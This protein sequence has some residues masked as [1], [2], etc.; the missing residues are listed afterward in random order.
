MSRLWH[1]FVVNDSQKNL[2][3]ALHLAAEALD[4]AQRAP[5][6]GHIERDSRLEVLDEEYANLMSNIFR[7]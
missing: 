3:K 1:N 2:L 6:L 7:G 4:L 5:H